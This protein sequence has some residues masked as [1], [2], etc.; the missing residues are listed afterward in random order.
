MV[1]WFLLRI[2]SARVILSCEFYLPNV[3]CRS[4]CICAI[5]NVFSCLSKKSMS[6]PNLI[7]FHHINHSEHNN[8]TQAEGEDKSA[9]RDAYKVRMWC[10]TQPK[11]I[12]SVFMQNTNVDRYSN[13]SMDS[14]TREKCEYPIIQ[15]N[16]FCHRI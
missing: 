12:R 1:V 6:Q 7:F 9:Q 3:R 4:F 13:A 15:S 11:R 2:S 14:I 5:R 10:L 8:N 16:V